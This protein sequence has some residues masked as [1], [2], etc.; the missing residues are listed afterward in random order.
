MNIFDYKTY[1]FDFDG[2]ILDS[3]FIK[4]NAIS[5]S[6]TSFIDDIEKITF[7]EYFISN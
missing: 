1:I 2:V 3:N 6:V 5:K 4:K 7:V